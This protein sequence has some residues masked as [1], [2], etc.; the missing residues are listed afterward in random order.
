MKEVVKQVG[1]EL[2]INRD[3]AE[4]VVASLLEQPRF[5]IYMNA[6]IN[7]AQHRI[8]LD[9]LALLKKGM[10][11]EY[12]TK[13]AHFR[14]YVL[15]IEPGVF[16]PRL[17]TE[18]FIELIAQHTKEPPSTIL[19]IGTGTG[20]IAIALAHLFP[21]TSIIATD[22]SET[23]LTCA[24]KNIEKYRLKN[25]ITLVRSNMFDGLSEKF[26]MI[27]SN[28]PYIPRSRLH[29]LPKSV[30]DFEPVQALDGGEKGIQFITR[31][32]L[33][34]KTHL[35]QNGIIAIEI[36]ETHTELLREFLTT[37]TSVSF[38]FHKDLF[39]RCRYLLI[40]NIKK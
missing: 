19:D 14:D 31:C 39:N 36:D 40:R 17:E 23:A 24:Q 2:G 27:V 18:Y 25:L 28:P 32:V 38:S 30:R 5:S 13:Q 7:D 33:S 1:K 11:I 26:D 12:V 15:H 29:M 37:S 20:A 6:T 22:I 4:L 9:K 21:D 3:E 16:I 34:G 8:L 10:P 35:E